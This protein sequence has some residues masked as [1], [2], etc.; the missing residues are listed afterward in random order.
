MSLRGVALQSLEA[1][2]F[3]NWMRSHHRG[4]S[5]DHERLQFLA[6]FEERLQSPGKLIPPFGNKNSLASH[7]RAVKG[8][9]VVDPIRRIPLVYGNFPLGVEHPLTH[10]LMAR[11]E[12]KDSLGR[13]QGLGD[14]LN[15]VSQR[16]PAVELAGGV[17]VGRDGDYRM[18]GLQVGQDS[19]EQGH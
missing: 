9:K 3:P 17:L 1:N 5:A 2:A 15:S 19:K 13:V 16:T 4:V 6:G 11:G 10:Q 18:H 8:R 14:S 7:R 12:E